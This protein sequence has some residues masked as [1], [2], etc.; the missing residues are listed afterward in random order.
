[1]HRVLEAARADRDVLGEE[2]A[3]RDAAGMGRIAHRRRRHER[4]GGERHLGE[5]RAALRQREEAQ[6]RRR[7][8][9][10][11][12]RRIAGNR[13]QQMARR[14]VEALDRIAQARRGVRRRPACFP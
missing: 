9:E 3:Q 11:L 8:G 10:R 7:A 12:A 1:M 14:P 2:A 13:L 5:R 4:V 6:I